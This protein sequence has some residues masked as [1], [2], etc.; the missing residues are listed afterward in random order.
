[1]PGAPAYAHVAAAASIPR[2]QARD[3]PLSEREPPEDW[4][5]WMKS[6]FKVGR[7]TATAIDGT[8]DLAESAV[9]NPGDIPGAAWDLGERA[10]DDPI[11]TGKAIVGYDLLASGRVEDWFGQAGFA[12]LTGGAGAAPSRAH[13]LNRVIGSPRI[14]PLGRLDSPMNAKFAGRRLDFGKPDLGAPPGS[15]RT[16]LPDSKREALAERYPAGVRYTRAGYP[17]FT[18]YAI[19]RL[20]V[21]GMDGDYDH[22]AVLA[23]DAA[24]LPETPRGYVWHHVEDGRNMEL[25]PQDLHRGARHTGGAADIEGALEAGIAPGGVPTPLEQRLGRA[26]AGGGVLLGGAGAVEGTQP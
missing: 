14:Q 10:V 19:E 18:P 1:M 8:V 21:D 15:R 20:A 13:R 22:D 7:G 11:G 17:V 6:W 24:G 5:G 16:T 3:V 9:E 4:P 25:V 23:N 2:P 12:A 26:G